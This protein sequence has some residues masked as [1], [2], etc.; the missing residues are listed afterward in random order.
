M[1]FPRIPGRDFL[2]LV[3][4]EVDSG[5]GIAPGCLEHLIGNDGCLLL[6]EQREAVS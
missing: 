4:A 3:F 1:A 2:Q 5:N 6:A